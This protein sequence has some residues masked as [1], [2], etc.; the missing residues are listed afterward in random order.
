M[1]KVQRHLVKNLNVRTVTDRKAET[2][3]GNILR[4]PFITTKGGNKATA[5]YR[6][7]VRDFFDTQ[8]AYRHEFDEEDSPDLS[9]TLQTELSELVKDRKM[10]VLMR[11]V[12]PD[13]REYEITHEYRLDTDAG[14]ASGMKKAT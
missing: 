11:R 4:K 7:N 14:R 8:Y 1:E 10:R 6:V 13:G 9:K 12:G 3:T 5:T 2:A